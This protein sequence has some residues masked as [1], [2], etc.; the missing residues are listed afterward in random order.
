M[1]SKTMKNMKK[2]FFIQI[3]DMLYAK[4]VKFNNNWGKNKYRGP[5]GS[6][7]NYDPLINW[8]GIGLRVLNFYDNGDNSWLSDK[9]I[10]GEWYK[11][12]HPIQNLWD[13]KFILEEGFI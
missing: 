4:G 6:L 5:P 13:L 12:Y 8:I 1:I 9:N 3:I 2:N 7:L 10:N 11:V